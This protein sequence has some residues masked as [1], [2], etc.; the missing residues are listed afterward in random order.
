MNTFELLKILN[1]KID[2]K[3]YSNVLSFDQFVNLNISELI[4]PVCLIVNTRNRNHV[5]QHWFGLYITEQ[6]L[7][8]MNSLFCSPK[9]CTPLFDKLIKTNKNVYCLN[10]RIQSRKT[11]SCGKF[12]LV[13]LKFMIIHNDFEAY[14]SLFKCE[15]F[16]FNENVIKYLYVKYFI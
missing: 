12:C 2:C 8:Y 14:A 7:F 10:S 5:G 3:G 11:S 15:D 16:I 9:I 1:E 4:C 6:N 13:F